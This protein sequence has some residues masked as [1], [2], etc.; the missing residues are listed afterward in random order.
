M[1]P[2]IHLDIGF[3]RVRLT[4]WQLIVHIVLLISAWSVFIYILAQAFKVEEKLFDK[5]NLLLLLIGIALS[6]SL[7]TLFFYLKRKNLKQFAA[8]E[9][10]SPSLVTAYIPA[11]EAINYVEINNLDN[12]D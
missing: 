1:K 10:S 12:N 7:A 5:L 11:T 3:R 4:L 9:N 2:F 6:L 8:I